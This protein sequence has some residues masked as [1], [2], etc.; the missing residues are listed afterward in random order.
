M[1]H[2]LVAGKLHPAGEAL[3]K[4]LPE[5][6]ITVDY[7][8]DTLDASYVPLIDKADALI[9]RTQPLTAETIK[10]AKRLKVVS[11]H[12]V[13]YD[14]IDLSALNKRNIALTIV[15]NINSI[16]V[17]EHAM[18]CLLAAAKQ[19]LRADHA[20][21]NPG[22]WDWR[23]KL[24]AREISGK[25]LLIIG[26]GRSGQQLAR[27]VGGFEMNVRA[28]DPFLLNSG[29]PQG[30]VA[31]FRELKDALGW[32]DCI[33]LHVP[34]SDKPIIGAEE[35]AQMKH[36]AILVNT[37]RGGVVCER[38][39]AEALGSGQI[40]AA[41]I[42]VFDVEPSDTSSPLLACD[43][44]I[45]SPHIAGLSAECG[46]RMALASIEN[47]LDYLSGDIDRALI[48]NKEVLYALQP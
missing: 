10:M 12:G 2:L 9:I 40:G 13:G 18:M 7:V 48:V 36:G 35:F 32:A 23:N 21:R 46:E 17:A 29:W 34:K 22:V 47:A 6:G 43:N 4:A 42:D 3:L 1:T 41:G 31:P 20:V 19:V 30:D 5:R 11:R 25:N 45:L 14:M 33:S 15:G 8:M 28:Y 37:S 16:S 26:Y 27:M 38:S 44:V 39:L 24:E